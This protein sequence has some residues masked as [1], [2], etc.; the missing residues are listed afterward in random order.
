VRSRPHDG[1]RTT[2]V[3]PLL[4][5]TGGAVTGNRDAPREGAGGSDTAA[6]REA[7]VRRAFETL[8]TAFGPQNWWPGDGP[9]EIMVGAVLTQNSSWRNVERALERMRDADAMTHSAVADLPIER[10]EELVRP[11]GS[12]RRKARTVAALARAVERHGG[13]PRAFLAKEPGRL[14]ETLLAVHG[15]GPETA[16]SILLYAGGHPVF[17]VDAYTRRY[18]ARHG[19]APERA[20]YADV[21]ELFE[22]ALG[23]GVEALAECHALMVEL[24]KR[25][26]RPTPSCPE[27]PLKGDLTKPQ[28]R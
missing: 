10:V 5:V 1:G 18:L 22:R 24:G 3:L 2:S 19:L 7:R 12:W 14:R 9:F 17:V 16:D 26:C 27:C 25:F 11:A 28:A 6:G 4:L 20:R 15:I 8:R 13:G 23:G 21:Q